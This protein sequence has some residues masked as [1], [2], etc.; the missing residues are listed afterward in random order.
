MLEETFAS[1][2]QL[3]AGPVHSL[4]AVGE[5]WATASQHAASLGLAGTDLAAMLPSPALIAAGASPD[6]PLFS[7]PRPSSLLLPLARQLSLV[8]P[9]TCGPRHWPRPRCRRLVLRAWT[10]GVSDPRAAQ[11]YRQRPE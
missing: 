4:L 7:R 11:E 6:H 8:S 5:V 10:I 1:H 3:R 2:H 9:E